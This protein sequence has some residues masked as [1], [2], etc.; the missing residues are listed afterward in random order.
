MT[1]KNLAR[2][3]GASATVALAGSVAFWV[4]LATAAASLGSLE[5]TDWGK[6]LVAV[7]AAGSVANVAAI[8]LLALPA[9]VSGW[10]ARLHRLAIITCIA[11]GSLF[12]L[13]L[14]VVGTLANGVVL[15]AESYSSWLNSLMIVV[16]L[17]T[18]VAVP[19]SLGFAIA[20][21]RA[22]AAKRAGDSQHIA[23]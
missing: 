15:S 2:W 7:T 9:F 21:A 4:V 3:A 19:A 5:L 18:L 22:S 6:L 14:P 23:A 11:I 1:A 8:M 10:E 13:Y 17:A 20:A 16:V 12:V